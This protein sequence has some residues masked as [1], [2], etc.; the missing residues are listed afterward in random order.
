MKWIDA[1]VTMRQQN[2]GFVLVTVLEVEGSAPRNQQSKMVITESQIFDSIGGGKL[3]HQA[4]QQARMMLHQN[5]QSS[6]RQ[7]Y[8]LGKDLTQC[9]GG[10]VEILFECF[11]RYDFNIVLCGAGHVGKAMVKILSDLPCRVTWTD[12]RKNLLHQAMEELSTP[13]NVIADV[14]QNPFALIEASPVDSLYLVMTHSHEIDFELCEAILGRKDVAYCGLIG[15][16]SK[17]AKFRSRLKRKGFSDTELDR[18]TSPIGL[19]LG[20]G[21]LPMEVAVSTAAQ[22]MQVYHQHKKGLSGIRNINLGLVAG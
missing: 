10:K 9:C 1:L 19:D 16:R 13:S 7:S 18:L 15:S 22:L 6:V 4:M 8:T 17:A 12:S 2:I 21:K 3:E 14:M 11:I 20:Q 5:V